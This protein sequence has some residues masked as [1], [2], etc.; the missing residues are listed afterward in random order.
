MV[1]EKE[2]YQDSRG[3]AVTMHNDASE[4]IL[5]RP[6]LRKTA[7]LMS[8]LASLEFEDAMF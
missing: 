2:L 4:N 6:G 5:N 3:T 7:S 1:L 8:S